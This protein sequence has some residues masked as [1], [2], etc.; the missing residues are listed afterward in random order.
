M[1]LNGGATVC[2]MDGS[3]VTIEFVYEFGDLPLI[4]ANTDNLIDSGNPGNAGALL[5]NITEQT[6]G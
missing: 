2:D 6:K 5:L 1:T 3:N 4:T